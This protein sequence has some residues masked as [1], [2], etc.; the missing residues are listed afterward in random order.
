MAGPEVVISR[1]RKIELL[2]QRIWR[3][4]SIIACDQCLGLAGHELCG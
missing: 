2:T 4:F 1:P 3:Y